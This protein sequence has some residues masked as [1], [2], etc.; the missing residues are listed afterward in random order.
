LVSVHEKG[1]KNRRTGLIDWDSVRH[2]VTGY[3]QGLIRIDTTNP[4]G[5][6]IEAARFISD[7]LSAEGFDPVVTESEPGRGNVTARL[8]GNGSKSAFMLLG[9]TDVVAVEAEKWSRPPFSGDLH[10]GCIWGRG[11]LDMKNMVALELMVLLLLKRQG[12]ELSRDV[13]FAATADEEA[14]K[15][16]HGIGW[17]LDND[18]GQVEAPV[19]LTEGGG[20]DVE[21][22]SQRYVTCQVAQKGICR[23]RIISSGEPG[24][25]SRPRRGSAVLKL[26]CAIGAL[27]GVELPLHASRTMAAFIEGIA[28]R[29]PADLARSL[30]ALLDPAS[31]RE[32]LARL[33]LGEEFKGELRALMG[34]TVAI[35]MLRG[36]TKI[37]VI[38]AEAT[39]FMDARLAPGQTA[40]SLIAELR[41]HIGDEVEIEIDQ[42]TEP[43]EMNAEGEFFNTISDVMAE[44]DPEAPVIPSMMTGGT[45]AKHICPRRPHTA[46]YGF[47]PYRQTAGEEEMN[48][49]HG[50]DER[51]SGDNLM[52]ATRIIYDIV[53]RY[54]R[55]G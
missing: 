54:C 40:A 22:G 30:R 27:D 42:Y 24:H 31:F 44:Y 38:P 26:S 11:A 51:I 9:H 43:L 33:P 46:V 39:A 19:V 5:N 12:L 2:E 47:T 35:T 17:L 14:G 55:A 32:E 6:E 21:V 16:N 23:G 28:A 37:N 8:R 18:P 3:L 13:I 1:R 7:I 20:H 36:G 45:D 48:L 29:Q 41:P 25:G 49:I 15:G 4:P 34:N 50:H 53:S 10:E 52:F